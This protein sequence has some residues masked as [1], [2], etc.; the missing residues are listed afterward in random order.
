MDRLH[1]METFALV[2]DTGSF[3][4]AARRLGTGQ[5]AVSKTVAALE[6]WLGVRLLA[7]T[8]RGLAPT[9]AGLRFHEHARRA[10]AE[11]EEAEHAARGEAASLSGPLRVACGTTFA[12]LFV[13][14]ALPGFLA[15]HPALDM[16]ILLDDR[17]V[18]LVEEGID[19]SLRMGSLPD[20]AAMA[21]R[22]GACPRS[23]IATPA[24]LARAGTPH[25]PAELVHHDAV[26][27]TQASVAWNFR[28]GSTEASAAPRPRLR[29]NASEGVRA[30]VLAGL[31]LTMASDWMFSP[32][33]A[34]GTAVRVLQGWS[35][36]PM[37]LWAVFPGG[38]L[39]T[40]KSRA[41]ADFVQGLVGADQKSCRP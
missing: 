27:F 21:R 37:E 35:L 32:E 3:S 6:Q 30:A 10:L 9:E 40:T 7:R 41:F 23:I 1:A 18:D 12:R 11:A 5:P 8:T 2:V 14:P 29:A 20:S 33:L 22:L 36:P 24:Y 13:I 31:G 4:A 25:S 15:A 16:E 26:L 39:T 34:N 38:R 19:L 28:Q 17:R